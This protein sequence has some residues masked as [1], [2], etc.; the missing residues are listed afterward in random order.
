MNPDIVIAYTKFKNYLKFNRTGFWFSFFYVT[1]GGIVACNIYPNDPLNG[2]WIDWGF[3]ITLPVNIISFGY[4]FTTK[5]SGQLYVVLIIQF[6]VFI[7]TFI[8]VSTLLSKF[9]NRKK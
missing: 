8:A 5:H 6:L 1:L 2:R 7:P 4:C 3:L 9:K